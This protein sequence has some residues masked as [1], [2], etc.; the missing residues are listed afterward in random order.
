LDTE[1]RQTLFLDLLLVAILLVGVVGYLVRREPSAPELRRPPPVV[2]S[3]TV[4]DLGLCSRRVEPH[5]PRGYGAGWCSNRGD[6]D[7]R[8]ERGSKESDQ[9]QAGSDIKQPDIGVR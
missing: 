6:R 2:S 9:E 5:P 4:F 1:R 3:E 8:P 7:I